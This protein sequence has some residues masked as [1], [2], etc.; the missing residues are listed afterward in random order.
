MSMLKA[1]FSLPP[2]RTLMQSSLTFLLSSL[3][4]FAAATVGARA[5]PVTLDALRQLVH[6]SGANIS[7]DGSKIVF[8]RS[9]GDYADDTW[10]RALVV[11]SV[12]SGAQRTVTPV[13][14]HLS[15]PQWS[16]SGERIAY[17]ADDKKGT[18]QVFVIPA[19]GGTPTQIT[20]AQRDVEQFSWE[21]SGERIAFVTENVPP[22]SATKR[23]DDLWEVHDDGFLTKHKPEPSHIWLASARGGPARRLT[24]GS[25][26]VLEAAPPF[27]GAPTD[28]SWSADGR[29]IT[30]TMQ[31]D[32]DDSDSDRTSI[33]T[34]DVATGRV[35]HLD[36]RTQYEYQ[37]LFAPQGRAIAYVYPHG[38]GPVSVMDVFVANNGSNA[39]VT[40]HLDKDV[41]QV[42]WLPNGR[43][44]MLAAD[45]VREAL[46][47]QSAAGE[48]RRLDLADL[49]PS[50]ISTSRGGTIAMIASASNR[51][52]EVYVVD[53]ASSKLRQLTHLNAA[54]AALDFGKSEELTWRA[55][56]GERSDGV[57]T[58]PPHY[59]AGKQYPLV[60]RI[61]GGPEASTVM[62]FD[63]LRQLFASHGY[64]VLQPNY[65]GSD[66]LGNAHEHAIYKDPGTGPG[67][68]VMAGVAA[69]EHLGIVDTSREAVTGH[70]YGGYMTTWLIGHWHNWRCA[71]VGDG[72]VDWVEEY[73]LSATGN[74]AWARDS[75]GGSPWL[76]ANVAIYHDGSPIS[77]V[78]DITTPTRIISGTADEQVPVSE[79]YELFH[80]LNDLGVPVSFVAIPGAHHFPSDPVHIEG[81]DR[82]T[83]EWVDRYMK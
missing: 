34:V 77:Y 13:M 83:L 56:D 74:L 41:T 50:Q 79:S 80:A 75:L 16:P 43:M 42:A 40:T 76:P 9:V 11:V 60:L 24:N 82:V 35:T 8:V 63:S 46:F 4:F 53:S 26:S 18:G 23:H 51:P 38:P 44:A 49:N 33:A 39:D 15:S 21:P 71:V 3:V 27:V 31:S 58:Y 65:R 28:P 1:L 22:A 67:Q 55:P 64:L 20:H 17:V 61:H 12:K 59:V 2:K 37:P 78:H 54:V 5:A 45:G 29:T 48:A 66:N 6:I 70:S 19:A 81:Y 7:A 52:D 25:W 47:V 32:A 14:K 36:A 69:V 72:M 57:L 30:F 10:K 73:D 62:S 68:D